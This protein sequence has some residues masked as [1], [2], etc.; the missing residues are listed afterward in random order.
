MAVYQVFSA[1]GLNVEVRTALA[2]EEWYSTCDERDDDDGQIRDDY[3]RRD[4]RIKYLKNYSFI[5]RFGDVG[6]MGFAERDDWPTTADE[7][8]SYP[9]DRLK[10]QWLTN[11]LNWRDVGWIWALDW[12]CNPPEIKPYQTSACLL[13][14]I[15]EASKRSNEGADMTRNLRRKHEDET[16]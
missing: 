3:S 10:V 15:P 16:E 7:V 8:E 6:T 1:L 12:S 13:V 9:A 2:H 4:F 14:A 5:G 11:R